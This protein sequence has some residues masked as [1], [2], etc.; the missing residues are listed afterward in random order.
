[1]LRQGTPRFNGVGNAA[2]LLILLV[3]QF[4]YYTSQVGSGCGAVVA[5]ELHVRTHDCPHCGLVLDRDVN[6]ARNVLSLAL[7]R[8]GLSR[9]DITWAVAPCVS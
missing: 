9:Q 7:E 8:L 4:V 2:C 3:I 6:A 1:M 5:K